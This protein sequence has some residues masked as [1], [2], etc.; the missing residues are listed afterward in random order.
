MSEGLAI[1]FVKQWDITYG[2]GY[3]TVS[4][5]CGRSYAGW[6]DEV[7]PVIE[8]HRASGCK[9]CR[10]YQRRREAIQRARGIDRGTPFRLDQGASA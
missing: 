7:Q 5:G 9:G 2:R 3:T 1:R 4:F 6:H 8:R 10:R